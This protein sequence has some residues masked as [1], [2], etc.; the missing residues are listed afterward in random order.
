MSAINLD[1]S[2]TP[3]T[4]GFTVVAPGTTAP[5][6]SNTQVQFNNNGLFGGTANVTYDKVTGVLGASKLAVT[7]TSNLNAV[8]NVTITGG[9]TGQYLQTD[10][11]G[12]LSWQSISTNGIAN[13]TSNVLIPSVNGN[14]N[15]SVG[16]IPNVFVVSAT[17]ANVAGTIAVTGRSNLNAVGNVTITG[18]TAGQYLQTDGAGVLSWQSVSGSGILAN[19]T[20]NVS[21]PAVNGNVN[22]SVGGVANVLVVTTTGANVD[23]T[24]AVTGRS[25]L[26]A[27]G[28]VTITGGTS[29]QVL[30]T[31]GS[32]V[33]SWVTGTGGVTNP[34]APLTAIQFNDGG[35]F[36][37]NANLTYN[38]AT[39]VVAIAGTANI[40]NI[41][42]LTT[43]NLGAVGNV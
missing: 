11:S 35:V 23:G 7:G 41:N 22:T 6:G 15:T 21:I 27:V 38:K 3:I 32:G 26:N 42:A 28:N 10:G 2:G 34:S 30:Q 9:T 1:I 43:A 4:L 12:V 36:G 14:V 20:S 24:L 16:G 37:G 29:G 33:L 17:G 40:G 19:G 5:G 31:N 13:G 25:N 18:G 8:G 39:D